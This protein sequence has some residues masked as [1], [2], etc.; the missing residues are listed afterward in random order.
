ML[1]QYLLAT[2]LIW[3]TLVC[4]HA[5][6][7]LLPVGALFFPV[8]VVCMMSFRNSAGLLLGGMMLTADWITRPT[9]L[10]VVPILLP[11]A[12]TMLLTSTAAMNEFSERR[13]GLQRVPEWFQP[14]LLT[15]LAIVA[16]RVSRPGVPVNLPPQ[17]LPELLRCAAIALPL[18]LVLGSISRMA[19]EFGLH[20]HGVSSLRR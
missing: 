3:A 9:P 6:P 7:D 2:L 17:L 15:A 13:R 18:S 12:T 20:R 1:K 4:E 14:A 19:E 10:P 8:V 5:R 11:L 16:V